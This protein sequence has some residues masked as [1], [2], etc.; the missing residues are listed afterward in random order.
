M[1]EAVKIRSICVD[2]L[3]Q[4]QENEY[5]TDSKKPGHDKWK[6]Y[7]IGIHRFAIDLQD[8]GFE[9]ILVL[10]PPGTG[11]ST[12]LRTLPSKTN[13]WF[14]CDNKNPVWTGGKLEYGKKNNPIGPYH[15]I[16]K[17]YSDIINH[18]KLGLEKGMFEEERFAILTG[19]L[20]NYKEGN[21]QRVRLK[22]LGS[23]TNKMQIEGKFET[24]LYAKVEVEGG[25]TKYLLETQNNGFNTA[26]SPQD[27]FEGK[28]DNDYNLVIEKLLM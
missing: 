9:I 17:T 24:V 25:E 14:N 26:R 8:L 23:L 2:T 3:T 10:G 15:V 16:P 22:T 13:I 28:I 4:I 5:M 12:G 6:D 1:S 18:I 20:E 21:E 7:A 19:H 27:V 11:K